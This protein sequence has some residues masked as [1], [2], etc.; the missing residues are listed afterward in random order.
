MDEAEINACFFFF[1]SFPSLFLCVLHMVK[2][3][4]TCLRIL[5][6]ITIN[7]RQYNSCFGHNFERDDLHATL[8]H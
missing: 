1:L 2:F 7:F 8:P 4:V 3:W 6:D 5:G